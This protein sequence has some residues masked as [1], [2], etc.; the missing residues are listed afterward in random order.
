MPA[1]PNLCLAHSGG[2][3]TILNTTAAA[4]VRAAQASGAFSKIYAAEFGLNGLLSGHFYDLTHLSE[5]ELVTLAQTPSSIFGSCRYKLPNYADQA[6]PY[7]KLFNTCQQFNIQYLLYQGGND[8]QDTTCKIAAAQQH[9]EHPL[10]VLGLPKTID[11]DLVGTD[12]CPGY[13]SAAKYIATSLQE[14]ALDTYAMSRNS[15]Q[16]FI[17]E[18]MGRHTGWLALAAGLNRQHPQQAPHC[19]LTPE[20]PF[21]QQQWLKYV[22]H[23]VHRYGF[24][25]VV[26]SEG[27]T[28][29][30]GQPIF[31]NQS[32]DAFGHQQLGGVGAYLANLVRQQAHLKAHWALPDYLQ[33]SAGHL[34]AQADVTYA[35]MLG[36]YAIQSI[37]TTQKPTMLGLQRC[38]TTTSETSWAINHIDLNTCANKERTLPRH[39]IDTNDYRLSQDAHD[40]LKPLLAGEVYPSY[41]HGIP[42]YF[43]RNQL[44]CVNQPI[45]CG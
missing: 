12:F 26:A 29:T 31:A 25:V 38:T 4:S 13:P 2:V 34:R 39:F 44:A 1:K 32:Q 21:C 23:C 30:S 18:V 15:T 28:D 27:I 11:N 22:Q 9:F 33:R 42:A 10:T 40:Y 36:E 16:V 35:E 20:H 7:Q 24:C 45:Y 5:Q 14:A 17:L 43:D 19:I 37:L 8:S 3:T 41:Q 6:E